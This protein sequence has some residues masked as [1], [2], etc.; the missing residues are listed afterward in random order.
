[1][2]VRRYS[3]PQEL[4]E[5][6]MPML[7]RDEAVNNWTIG[8][9]GDSIRGTRIK[10]GGELTLLGI[11]TEGGEVVATAISTGESLVVTAMDERAISALLEFVGRERTVQ[12]KTSGPLPAVRTFATRWAELRK[13]AVQPAMRMR[14]MR[15]ERVKLPRL[16]SGALRAA[17]M[18]DVD[19]LAP[20]GEGFSRELGFEPGDSRAD[21]ARRVELGR[22]YLWCDPNPVSMAGLAGP[23]PNGV[24]VNSVYTPPENRGKGYARA[25]VSRLSQMMLD[26]GKRFVFLYVD[27][28]NPTTNRLYSDIGFE[29]VCDW[30]DWRFEW[31]SA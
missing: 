2:K 24:R 4:A 20:W 27:A 9:L 22:L 15:L 31:A 17:T 16:I 12:P 23:T 29:A 26:A 5:R 1:M 28:E 13:V 11:E 6:A 25:G 14:I 3:T 7:L 18:D 8:I 30:E 21:I 19:L 10:S